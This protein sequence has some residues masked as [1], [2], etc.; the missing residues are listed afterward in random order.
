MLM[1]IGMTEPLNKESVMV[2]SD[3]RRR[4]SERDRQTE[5]GWGGVGWWVGELSGGDV[6][7]TVQ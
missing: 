7:S 3:G 5:R 6:G 2:N 1:L 4:K